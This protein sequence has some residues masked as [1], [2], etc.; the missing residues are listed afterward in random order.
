MDIFIELSVIIFLATIVSLVM[1]AMKQP[2]IVGYII[3][4]LLIG[5]YLL[6]LVHSKGTIELFSKI[7]IIILLFIVGLNLNPKVVKEVGKVS[8]LAGIAQVV[9]TSIVGF[10]IAI[11]LGINQVAAMY[12]AIALTLSSTIIILKLITDKGDINSLYAKIIVGVLIIQD[13]I[14]SII[15]L[16]ISTFSSNTSL[17]LTTLIAITI[18]K[19]AILIGVM[20]LFSQHLLPKLTSY[21]A[22]SQELLFLFSLCWGMIIASLFYYVG[23]SVEI[24]ALVAGVTLA[25]THYAYEISSRLKPLRD[26]F[27]LLFFILLGSQMVISDITHLII[28]A[29][30]L[31]LFVL[32]G[33]PLIVLIIMNLLGFHRR[34]GLKAGLTVA[35]IS[36]FSLI[37]ATLG[38]QVGHLDQQTVSLITLVGLITIAGSTYLMMYDDHIFEKFD[39]L[40][41]Y[42]EFRKSTRASET[43]GAE[44]EALLFGYHRAGQDVLHAFNKLKVPHLVID[45]NPESINQLESEQI[46][47]K[48]GDAQ[49]LEFLEELNLH[50]AKLIVSTIPEFQ[51]NKLLIE[52]IRAK[53]KKAVIIVLSQHIPHA[54]QLYEAGANYVTMPH[55]LSAQ[56][57]AKLIADLGL[58]PKAFQEEKA[59][60]LHYLN[61]HLASSRV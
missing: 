29:L 40:L 37:L 1:R 36:E 17:D 50:K 47:Y 34:I 8:A 44:Y 33:N 42:F 60:H 5:P 46:P 28:P 61:K 23:F 32:V 24:G 30:I 7:G 31:S 2:L 45:F 20:M 54:L 13:I 12:I 48:Y 38:M 14:A 21:V 43:K 10:L 27:V 18:G 35:Q 3:T 51:T 15:L 9:L 41:K 6:N 11:A 53:N 4:G 25:S 49:D 59:K 26:F 39:T 16:V 58:D 19:G 22:Q 52:K 56:Y 55:Y 57:V